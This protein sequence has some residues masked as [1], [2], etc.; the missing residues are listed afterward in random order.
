MGLFTRQATIDQRNISINYYEGS[1][2]ITSSP[3]STSAVIAEKSASVAPAVIVTSVS[4][5]TAYEYV[6]EMTSAITFR[7]AGTPGM[8]AY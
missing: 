5:S 8:G 4:G 6:F 1:N 3:L 2:K 7:K